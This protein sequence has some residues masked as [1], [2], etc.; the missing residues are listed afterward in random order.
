[1]TLRRCYHAR[2]EKETKSVI[3]QQQAARPPAEPYQPHFTYGLL[4]NHEPSVLVNNS[5]K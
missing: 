3:E 4:R 2:S 5:E 1:M